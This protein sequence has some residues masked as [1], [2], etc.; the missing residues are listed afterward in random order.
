MNEKQQIF[1]NLIKSALGPESK[2]EK[3]LHFLN[4]DAGT[5]KSFVLTEL[6]NYA[7]EMG[8]PCIP[9]AKT[10]WAASIIGGKTVNSEF[11]M[12]YEGQISQNICKPRHATAELLI[13]D[14]INF[15]PMDE[16]DTIEQ[17]F[18][19]K[20][21]NPKPFGGMVVVVAGDFGQLKAIG[22]HVYNSKLWSG[23]Q[24]FGLTENVRQNEPDFV[25]QL[26]SIRNGKNVDYNYWQKFVVVP[27]EDLLLEG[28]CIVC[29][30]SEISSYNDEKLKKLLSVNDAY[31]VDR[32]ESSVAVEQYPADIYPSGTNERLAK[33]SITKGTKIRITFDI[34]G[35][36][37][38][39]IC[40]IKELPTT[41]G[42][43]IIAYNENTR[44][45]ISIERITI[46]AKDYFNVLTST[47]YPFN[48]GWAIKIQE[49]QGITVDNLIIDR[50]RMSND[51]QVYVALSRVRSAKGLILLSPIESWNVRPSNKFEG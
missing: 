40:T 30:K 33:F 49:A 11:D 1:V 5:G 47:G 23:F 28:L 43:A 8:I 31:E 19:S 37:Y 45:I 13:I 9:V 29:D 14:V 22:E 3:K 18:C 32:E 10:S 2:V 4:G 20:K 39:H 25:E 24:Q 27:N 38:G 51:G 36:S 50:K 6:V 16:F 44:A 42:G 41:E 7:K 46:H 35:A 17:Y 21:E 48:Y 15:L 26:L 34:P 12:N